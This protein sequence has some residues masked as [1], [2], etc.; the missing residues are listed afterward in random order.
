MAK[1]KVY[2]EETLCKVIEVEIPE[3]MGVDERMELAEKI[4]L[5]QY[6]NSEIVLT[7]DDFTGASYMVEDVESGTETGWNDI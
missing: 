4:V 7:A 3:N 1:V 5:H 6:K 2:I